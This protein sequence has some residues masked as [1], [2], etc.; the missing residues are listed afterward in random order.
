MCLLIWSEIVEQND[1]YDH[2][3]HFD[4]NPLE[5]AWERTSLTTTQKR[6]DSTFVK[7]WFP[8]SKGC[9]NIFCLRILYWTINWF[10]SRIGPRRYD[11]RTQRKPRLR[12][13]NIRALNKLF[14]SLANVTEASMSARAN[15]SNYWQEALRYWYNNNWP[16]IHIILRS[17][18]ECASTMGSD[19]KGQKWFI[20][21]VLKSL[22]TSEKF[23]PWV[24]Y[25]RS[26]M[27]GMK[28]RAERAPKM[29]CWPG[30][31]RSSS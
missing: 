20:H 28:R 11:M 17:P 9:E 15:I 27:N 10:L 21:K 31:G 5:V 2:L 3:S 16:I 4:L 25:L 8:P 29:W 12:N 14:S 30:R 19:H 6:G 22:H 26:K 18:K 7:K 1:D 23:S 24:L 13:A